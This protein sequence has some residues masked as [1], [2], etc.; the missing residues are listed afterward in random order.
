MFMKSLK[1]A[2]S[3]AALAASAFVASPANA[4]EPLLG[5]VKLFG[6]N[7]CPRGWA[8]AD[9]QLLPINQNQSLY[10]LYGNYYGGDAR[11]TFGLPDLRGR[12]PV[13]YGTGPGLSPYA[14]GEKVGAE[15]H[16]LNTLEMPA[17]N[18][19]V[20]ATNVAA[21]KLGPDGK[22]LA[23]PQIVGNTNL[24]AY[25][26]TPDRIVQMNPGMISNTGGSQAFNIRQPVLAMN[27]CVAL[28][29][30]FPSRN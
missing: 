25:H 29:G 7:F 12:A 8:A 19:I 28:T 20:N 2:V 4:Q 18:H 22:Y 17:H 21:D 9:G 3:A 26:A 23:D 30:V 16:T 11:T 5:E 1:S 24:F 6:F 10:A 13:S 14:I 27:W 15:T